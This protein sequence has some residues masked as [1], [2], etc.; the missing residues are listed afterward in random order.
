[1]LREKS[2]FPR[3]TNTV[4]QVKG[5]NEYGWPRLFF[6]APDGVGWKKSPCCNDCYRKFLTFVADYPQ[7]P[8][9]FLVLLSEIW[10]HI[11]NPKYI[12]PPIPNG[13]EV[14]N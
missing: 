6:G 1:M 5:V 10:Y 9:E 2:D 7:I 8:F 3:T 11:P 4:L 12:P 14:N 13:I